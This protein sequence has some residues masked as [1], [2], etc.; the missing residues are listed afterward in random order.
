MKSFPVSRARLALLFASVVASGQ[1]VRVTSHGAG[2]VLVNEEQWRALEET[3]H[4]LSAPPRFGAAGH[5]STDRTQG[6][7]DVRH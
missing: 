5:E 3:L 4:R 1:P 7:N 6:G 2:V